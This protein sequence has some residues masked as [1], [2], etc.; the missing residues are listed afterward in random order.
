MASRRNVTGS[1]ARVPGIR[2][3]AA[4]LILVA[5]FRGMS[6]VCLGEQT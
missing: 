2:V 6:C 3:D 5:C 4:G 1:L